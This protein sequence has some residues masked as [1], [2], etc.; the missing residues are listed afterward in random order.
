MVVPARPFSA[1]DS[2]EFGLQEARVPA[3]MS[4]NPEPAL[5]PIDDPEDVSVESLAEDG[6]GDITSNGPPSLREAARPDGEE[7]DQVESD[8]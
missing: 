3:D 5:P 6:W 1:K 4:H 7:E 2:G 8:H